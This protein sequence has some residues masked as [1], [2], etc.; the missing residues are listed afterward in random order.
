MTAEMRTAVDHHGPQET[1]VEILV[2][3]LVEIREVQADRVEEGPTAEAVEILV[4]AAV[5]EAISDN[6]P[7]A[8]TSPHRRRS[9]H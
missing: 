5:A 7:Q 6:Q 9:Q 2:G 1:L 4:A 3:I 8:A